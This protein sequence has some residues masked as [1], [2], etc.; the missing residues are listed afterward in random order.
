MLYLL[1]LMP[2]I[3]TVYF[4]DT[5]DLIIIKKDI[6]VKINDKTILEHKPLV[7]KITY[8]TG[9]SFLYQN[10]KKLVLILN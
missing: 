7:I 2:F 5:D 6:F 4:Y 10:I 3:L 1:F 8:K 9:I